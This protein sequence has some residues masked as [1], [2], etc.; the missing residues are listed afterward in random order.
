MNDKP[1]RYDPAA[2]NDGS[3]SPNEFQAMKVDLGGVM[4]MRG[5]YGTAYILRNKGKVISSGNT[6]KQCYYRYKKWPL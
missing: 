2:G 6:V 3:L 4:P 1:R 5:E